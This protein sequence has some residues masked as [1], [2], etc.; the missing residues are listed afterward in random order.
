M[1]SGTI[2]NR[3]IAAMFW[4]R[5]LVTAESRSDPHAAISSQNVR[6]LGLGAGLIVGEEATATSGTATS[7]AAAAVRKA[8][9]FSSASPRT[10]PIFLRPMRITPQTSTNAKNP[11]DQASVCVRKLK[12]GSIHTGYTIKPS[13][14]PKLESANS[15]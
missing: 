13:S 5:W 9:A 11:T 3:G 2:H 1:V 15:L 14:D 7:C 12:F 6:S 10:S 4:L 8:A